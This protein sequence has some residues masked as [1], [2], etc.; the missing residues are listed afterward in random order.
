MGFGLVI[1]GY[2]TVLGVM[3]DTFVYYTWGIYIAVAGALIMLA[4]LCRLAEYNIY[5]KITKYICVAYVFIL[6]CFAPF[7]IL[8]LDA[9]LTNSF[10]VV[11][12]VIRTCLLFMFHFYLF[13]AVSALSHEIENIKLEKKAKRNIVAS[14]VFFAAFALEIFF[15][16]DPFMAVLGLGY[17]V[18]TLI[19]LYGCYMRITYEGHDEA[20]EAKYEKTKNK[21]KKR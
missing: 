16:I 3:P 1:I 20:I 14:C 8:K 21:T 9:E 15:P 12:K 18:F 17:Y 6:L 19:F 7:V 2:L 5:F 11:S 4:G 13:S 10:F